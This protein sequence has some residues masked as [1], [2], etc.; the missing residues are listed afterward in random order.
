MKDKIYRLVKTSELPPE[1]I[2]DV[3]YVYDGP[4][5]MPKF[6]KEE[7]EKMYQKLFREQIKKHPEFA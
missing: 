2:N 6:T 7:A 4:M 5:K 1:E 3:C